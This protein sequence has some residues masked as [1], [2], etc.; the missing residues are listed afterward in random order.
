MHRLQELCISPGMHND[1]G[2]QNEAGMHYDAGMHNEEGVQAPLRCTQSDLQ[3]LPR[4][5]IQE[6]LQ[7][8]GLLRAPSAQ[9]P[10]TEG[11]A[12]VL[13][14]GTSAKQGEAPVPDRGTS[15]KQGEAP[16]APNRERHQWPQ[17]GRGTS[18]RQGHHACM[19]P[20]LRE[21]TPA[22]SSAPD[23]PADP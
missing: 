6:A 11:E 18:A 1:A 14:R 5:Q 8:V 3:G 10:Q 12:P 22:A 20:G 13:D 4:V 21:S 23:L 16:V 17:T 15:A 19:G 2:M 9:W 7:C